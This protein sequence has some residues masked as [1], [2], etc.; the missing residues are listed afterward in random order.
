MVVSRYQRLPR[1]AQRPPDGRPRVAAIPRRVWAWTV[2][3]WRWL[4]EDVWPYPDRRLL[5]V[6]AG[7]GLYGVVVSALLAV[8]LAGFLAAGHRGMAWRAS[9]VVL[10]AGPVALGVV[11]AGRVAAYRRSHRRIW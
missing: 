7:A 3:A 9:W 11:L 8:S 2:E 4:R 1:P 5:A 6:L 10:L